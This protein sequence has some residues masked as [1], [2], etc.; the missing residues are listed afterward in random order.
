[1]LKQSRLPHRNLLCNLVALVAAVV[2]TLT[3]L[4]PSTLALSDS[5]WRFFGR[6]GITFYNPDANNNI[7]GC[8]IGDISIAG[9]AIAEKIWTGLISMGLT[10]EQAA[11]VMGNM[12]NESGFNPV[13]HEGSML[14][15]HPGFDIVNDASISYGIGLIQWSFGRRT[16]LLQYINSNAP[17]LMTYFLNPKE[18]G[19]VN[20]TTFLEKAG[21]G[22]TNQLIQI[23]LQF[24]RD[25]LQTFWPGFF[26]TSSVYDAT[27]FFLEKVEVPQNP[28]I[29]AHMSRVTN[30]DQYYQLYS[31]ATFTPISTSSGSGVEY[32]GNTSSLQQLVLKYAWPDFHDAPYTTQKSEYTAIVAQRQAAGK[33]VGGYGGNDCGG[34]VTT[35]LQESGFAPDYNNNGGNAAGQ[36]A[37]VKSH[38]WV[39][40]NGSESSIVDTSILQPGDVAFSGPS[41][42][43]SHTFVYV[44]SI[45]GF[46]SKIASASANERAPMAGAESLTGGGSI[47]VRWYRKATSI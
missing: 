31:G 7:M 36:E 40:L 29:E 44:G 21:Q 43:A 42:V 46:G 30:A 39:L 15:A 1:M 2:L 24:L 6:N 12:T 3:S 10:P 8:Y 17:H 16:R 20:G 28:Y 27:K 45:A 37:W 9:S 22:V 38:G 35:L 14:S 32:C 18:Y 19:R 23:E 25:E 33:Y 5:Q 11:G 47:P 26:Q 13:R 4:T 34:F 41:G